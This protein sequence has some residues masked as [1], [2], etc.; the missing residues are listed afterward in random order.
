VKTAG[1]EV[2]EGAS[3]A[4]SEL[5]EGVKGDKPLHHAVSD[6]GTEAKRA[7]EDVSKDAERGASDAK[8][9]DRMKNGTMLDATKAA[10]E[11]AGANIARTFDD[12]TTK[13]E[14]ASDDAE[15]K[16]DRETS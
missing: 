14:R 12:A 16:A 5:K 7:G 15:K 4:G 6:A 3:A 1:R 13:A 2:K 8:R 11:Q 9:E 10:F